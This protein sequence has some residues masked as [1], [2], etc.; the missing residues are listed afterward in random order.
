VQP[1]ENNKSLLSGG[2]GRR[3]KSSHSDQHFFVA[4]PV[5]EYTW[6]VGLPRTHGGPKSAGFQ[7]KARAL[8]S[9]GGACRPEQVNYRD[10]A[11][12]ALHVVETAPIGIISSNV[13]PPMEPVA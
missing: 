4:N 1:P 11:N 7:R 2:R 13:F 8:L 3:F 12:D 10:R 5:A 9:D 6:G